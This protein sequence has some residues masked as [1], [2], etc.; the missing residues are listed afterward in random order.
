MTILYLQNY[1]SKQYWNWISYGKYD[2]DLDHFDSFWGHN[3]PMLAQLVKPSYK[4]SVTGRT[5][6]N[7][8]NGS[9][10]TLYRPKVL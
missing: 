9:K 8:I 2:G 1:G 4:K 3:T 6:L 7:P 5:R 10:K